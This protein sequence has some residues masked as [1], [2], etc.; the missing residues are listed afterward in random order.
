MDRL[1]KRTIYAK[2][3]AEA[4]DVI[5]KIDF[6][7]ID[8][9]KIQKLTGDI[10]FLD[11]SDNR[12]DKKE[13]YSVFKNAEPDLPTLLSKSFET[14]SRIA[15]KLPHDIDVAELPTLFHTTLEKYGLYNSS[16]FCF[17]NIVKDI[18]RDSVL[19]LR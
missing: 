10:V 1:P 8:F 2:R 16:F 12:K 19:R 3:N 15:L 4:I 7:S 9:L 17:V 18:Q 5:D 13:P 11:P 14:S 6:L